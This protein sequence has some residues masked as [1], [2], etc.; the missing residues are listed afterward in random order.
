[1]KPSFSDTFWGRNL[2]SVPAHERAA[3]RAFMEGRGILYALPF[4]WVSQKLGTNPLLAMFL[5]GL[6]HTIHALY[7]YANM[8]IENRRTP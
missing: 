5:I 2:G 8:R 1:M 7:L 6:T 4:V 3:Y